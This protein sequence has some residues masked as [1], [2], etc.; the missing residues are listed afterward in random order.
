M[1]GLNPG[2]TILHYQ[3][4]ELL[5]RGGMGEVYKAVD[6]QLGRMVALKTLSP[7]LAADKTAHQRFLREAR[8]ASL[9]SHPSICTIFEVGQADDLIFIAM[10]LVRGRTLEAILSESTLP[11]ETAL[12]YAIDIADALDEAHRHGIIHRDIKPPNVIV[13]ERG[14]AVVLDFGLA[15]QV[16]HFEGQ[17][18]EAPTLLPL[19]TATMILGTPAYMSPEQVRGDALDHRSDIFSFGILLYEMVTG[20]RPFG[21]ASRIDLLHSILYDEPQQVVQ[22]APH[23]LAEMDA[24]I[25][26]SLMKNPADRYQ[27][28]TELKNDLVNLIHEKGYAVRGISSTPSTAR[29]ATKDNSATVEMAV[30]TGVLGAKTERI[31]SSPFPMRN[32]LIALLAGVLII[33][34]GWW[35]LF[36][37]SNQA[38]ADLLS[39][40]RLVPLDNWRSEP[41][42][43]ESGANFSRD[44]KMIVYSAS[45]GG[46]QNI[47]IK[48]TTGGDPVQVTKGESS[49]WSPIWSPDGQ[50]IAFASLRGGQTGIWSI[51]AFGGTPTLLKMLEGG[52]R[53][54]LKFWSKNGATVY[55]EMGPN[56][57]GLDL[58]SKQISQV[59][60]FDS[61]RSAPYDF[62]VSPDENRVAYV[63]IQD[64]ERDIWSIPA[65]GGAPVRLTSDEAEDSHPVWH[66]DGKRIIYSSNRD[67]TFQICMA[68]LDQRKPVQITS[69]ESDNVVSD[70]SPD[71]AKI[72]YTGSKEESDLWAVKTD[73]GEEIEVTSDIGVELWPDISPDGKTMAFQ[74][75]R[76]P[77]VG[78]NLLHCSIMTRPTTGAGQQVQLASDGFDPTWLP[79]GSKLGFLR[80]SNNE[81]NIWTASAD[82][83][84]KQVTTGGISFGGF[85]NLP[86]DR[87]QTR[88]YSWSPDGHSVSYCSKKSGQPNVY[89]ASV[90]GSGEVKISGNADPSASLNCPLWSPDGS[91]IAYIQFAP[92]DDGKKIWSINVAQQDKLKT[93]F[94][95]DSV[96]RLIGWSA[97][98]NSVIVGLVEGRPQHVPTATEVS[99]LEVSAAASN[100]RVI[101]NLKSAYPVN[102]Q[103]SPDG[104]L[105]AFVSRQD[106][107]D[108]IWIIA[109]TGGEAKKITSNSEP[110]LY[111]SSLTWSPDGKTIYYGKQGTRS[112]I[113]M[114]DNF[115]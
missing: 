84:E 67:G 48:Q 109:T 53:P 27:S 20:K 74:S 105:I 59:T 73:T 98:G 81:T 23:A 24:I 58:R 31:G 94:Q 17:G 70:V 19:T 90:D 15:K 32:A 13:N 36:R 69:V 45:R 10:Q 16:R 93:I 21:G 99:L 26:K 68:Y 4:K 57:F 44:G 56:L 52:R 43:V 76:E 111:F 101:A 61:S 41:G 97:T 71:G 7:A 11:I 22:A 33:G 66:P 112:L 113:S 5:G 103:L 100:R 14:V 9:L 110:G 40:L 89:A 42:E 62:S 29:P 49:D 114:I 72:I 63:D 79:D 78:R 6:V 28:A 35:F 54:T 55:Y 107:K 51:P 1:S 30:P 95:S 25:K 87:V 8:S 75:I 37:P 3:I 39:S 115:R 64:D 77:G 106:G 85:F 65:R 88:D 2:S 96:F 50:Q 83:G 86:Y 46:R 47:W 60:N 104:K 102:I 18:E 38:D 80:F 12:A 92:F 91:R 34:V 82:G 108:N